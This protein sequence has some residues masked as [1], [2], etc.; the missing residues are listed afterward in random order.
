MRCDSTTTM[1]RGGVPCQTISF[2]QLGHDR[3]HA[4]TRRPQQQ[5]EWLPIASLR[6]EHGEPGRQRSESGSYAELRPAVKA[7]VA[8]AH[9]VVTDRGAHAEP[10]PHATGPMD[11]NLWELRQQAGLAALMAV[12]TQITRGIPDPAS[13][14]APV[15]PAHPVV[16]QPRPGEGAGAVPGRLGRLLLRA[17]TDRM[18]RNSLYLMLSTALQAGLGSVFWVLMAR[19]FTTGEVGEGT[20]LVSATV[21]IG[22]FAMFGLNGSLVR[23]LPTARDYSS[24]ITSSFLVVTFGAAVAG[25]GYVR[26]LP[27]VA[28]RLAFVEEH[29]ALTVGFV[30]LSIGFTLNMLTDAVFMAG[31]RAEFCALT[32]GVVAGLCKILC[33]VALAGAGAYGLLSAS[34]GGSVAAAVVSIGLIIVVLRWRPS[35]HNPFHALRPVL[36]FSVASY[37][38]NAIYLLPPVVIPLII[39]DRLGTS[40]SAYY[41]M[42]SQ[43]AA[44]LYAAIYAV[45]SAFFA[46]GSQAG[47]D[48]R[49]IRRHSRRLAVMLFVPGGIVLAVTAHWILLIF[50][51]KYSAHGTVT[52]ELMALAVVPIAIFNWAVTV[53]RLLN[54][55]RSLLLC[56]VFYTAGVCGSAWVLASRGLNAVAV[57]WLVGSTAAAIVASVV[58]ASASHRAR[59]RKTRSR[60]DQVPSLS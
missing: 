16:V 45:E 52:L 14:T 57:S 56:S 2:R 40:S 36:K 27:V 18:V 60:P 31:R 6:A 24:L 12:A 11:A 20:S 38:S 1:P 44:L 59:H 58:A 26:F 41:Y 48:W 8:N 33:G 7:R 53:L 9:R 10:Q 25:F 21:Y 34:I 22:Q 28:P 15:A 32:D 19:L 5:G 13:T 4:M 29:P 49:T 50:G 17:R 43:L 37:V 47:V 51:Q 55:L 30:L 46:E 23:Y 54:R 39:L 3:R 35:L 42:V